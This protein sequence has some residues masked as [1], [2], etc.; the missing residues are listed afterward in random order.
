MVLVEIFWQSIK[1][2]I[3]K[4]NKIRKTATEKWDDYTTGSSLDF[5]YFKD[6][7]KLIGLIYHNKKH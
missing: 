4:Y 7:Y 3:A 2:N 5:A 1:W 6:H